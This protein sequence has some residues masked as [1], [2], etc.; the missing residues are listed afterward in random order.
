MAVGET[1]TP[2]AQTFVCSGAVPITFAGVW[3][4]SDPAV[5]AVDSTSGRV[6]GVKV[7]TVFVYARHNSVGSLSLPDSVSVSVR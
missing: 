3:Y 4:S 1:F 5:A 7:G 6:T 2:T